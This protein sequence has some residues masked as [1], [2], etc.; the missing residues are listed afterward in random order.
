M[1][2]RKRLKKVYGIGVNDA[3]YPI[4]KF[5]YC[6]DSSGVLKVSKRVWTC[7]YYSVW[8]DMLRRCYSNTFHKKNVTYRQAKVCK[9][10]L[11]FSNFKL[12]MEKQDWEGK[13]LD[14]DLIVTGNTLYSPETCVFISKELNQFF[15]ERNNDR[16]DYPLGVTYKPANKKYNARCSDP[17]LKKRVSLG[18]YD[19]PEEA[20]NS[21]REYKNMLSNKYAAQLEEEGY[22]EHV[23]KALRS[24]YSKQID[25]S[26]NSQIKGGQLGE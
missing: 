26:T 15:K 12:W 18:L 24:R 1:K 19:T 17:F 11:L 2:L 5:E 22:P 23:I 13:E 9:K 8:R 14:K 10:W 7:P 20:H 3:Q 21:W 6:R 16:G 4:H 25:L